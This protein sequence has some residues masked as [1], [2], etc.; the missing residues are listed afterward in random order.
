VHGKAGRAET[1]TDPAQLDMIESVIMLKPREQWPKH[2]TSRWHSA[3]PA[4]LKVPLRLLWSDS[5]KLEPL[6]R[7]ELSLTSV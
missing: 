6:F 1:A 3:A 7:S 5:G 4:W 2:F